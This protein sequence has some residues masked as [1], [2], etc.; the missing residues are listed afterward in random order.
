MTA[1][2]AGNVNRGELA[3][4]PLLRPAAEPENVPGLIVTQHSGEGAA[5]STSSG[6]LTLDHNT[7]LA[8]GA[9]NAIG[10]FDAGNASSTQTIITLVQDAGRRL[11]N[12]LRPRDRA[13]TGCSV[14]LIN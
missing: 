7:D 2:S 4:Q 3:S 1:A 6:P 5:T 14:A 11:G 10:I 9:I 8:T 13:S 12:D